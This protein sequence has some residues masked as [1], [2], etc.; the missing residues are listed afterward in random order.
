MSPPVLPA[1]RTPPCERLRALGLDPGPRAPRGDRRRRDGH[2]RGCVPRP[3]RA[4]PI[5]CRS[6]GRCPPRL[7][8]PPPPCEEG[9]SGGVVGQCRWLCILRRPRGGAP[10]RGRERGRDTLTDGQRAWPW[11]RRGRV[12]HQ[13]PRARAKDLRVLGRGWHGSHSGTCGR[14]GGVRHARVTNIYVY[15]STLFIP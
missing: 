3:L 13:V 5:A 15:A 7:V 8:A 6:R 11:A 2:P 10:P 9:A 4:P 1:G 14:G 12:S